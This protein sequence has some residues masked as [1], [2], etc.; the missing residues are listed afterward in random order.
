MIPILNPKPFPKDFCS[1]LPM[2]SHI[3]KT[4]PS[5]SHT[6]PKAFPKHSQ[7]KYFLSPDDL[8]EPSHTR[9]EETPIHLEI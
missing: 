6:V 3:L 9:E 4:F 5:A 7:T 2:A 8:P 1:D